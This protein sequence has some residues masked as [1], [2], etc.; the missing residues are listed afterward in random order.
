MMFYSHLMCRNSFLFPFCAANKWEPLL[1]AYDS[2][3]D[4]VG[5]PSIPG[6]FSHCNA[7]KFQHRVWRLLHVMRLTQQRHGEVLQEICSQSVKHLTTPTPPNFLIKAAFTT[8]EALEEFDQSLNEEQQA[9]LVDELSHLGGTDVGQA[10]RSILSYLLT[11]PAASEY[12][13]LGQK[14]KKKFSTLKLPSLI[15]QA[16]RRNKKLATA[17]KAE[18]ETA[19][20]SWLRHA[21]ERCK[22]KEAESE[23]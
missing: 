23:G 7:A 22:S 14:G 16:V 11:G 21:K 5:M 19:I 4:D 13:W 9:Q 6:N 2:D 1:E 15:F 17:T 20:K 18:V 10:T 8:S 3:P 12:S